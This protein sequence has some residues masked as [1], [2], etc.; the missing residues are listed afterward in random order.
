MEFANKFENFVD[1]NQEN[2]NNVD[3]EVSEVRNDDKIT[4]WYF[5]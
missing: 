4:N 5:I 1:E 2:L 3:F